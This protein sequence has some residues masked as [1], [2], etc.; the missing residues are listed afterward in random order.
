MRIDATLLGGGANTSYVDGF[1]R[2][3]DNNVTLG[4]V[5][6]E[7]QDFFIAGLVLLNKNYGSE[8]FYNI[9]DKITPALN[10]VIQRT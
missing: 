1:L 8:H 4:A 10:S 3:E 6:P 5:I 7:Y 2:D 9:Q